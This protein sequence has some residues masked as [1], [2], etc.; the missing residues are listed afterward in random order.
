VA[1]DAEL[2]TT[3]DVSWLNADNDEGTVFTKASQVAT[4]DQ[5]RLF[6][7][8][9]SAAQRAVDIYTKT[10][11]AVESMVYKSGFEM[12]VTTAAAAITNGTS[13][14]HV[15][16]WDST[17]PS[18]G[19]Y[20]DGASS[21]PDTTGDPTITLDTATTALGYYQPGPSNYFTGHVEEVAYWPAALSATECSTMSAWGL[22]G[23]MQSNEITRQHNS[24]NAVHNKLTRQ[25]R[26][27]TL[28][29]NR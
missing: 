13:F 2:Y 18:M 15:T 26:D 24:V 25:H 12:L 11:N 28:R 17:D 7:V 4:G 23:A 9:K 6:G 1:R 3:T 20:I 16:A 21:T 5:L 19:S 10:N 22:V 14:T 8:Y 27:P 29:H